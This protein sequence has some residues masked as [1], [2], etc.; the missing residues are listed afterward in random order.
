MHVNIMYAADVCSLLYLY[1]PYKT[2]TFHFNFSL[3]LCS[4]QEFHDAVK[5][6][7]T[8]KMQELIRRGVDIKIK[9]KVRY[10]EPKET[11]VNIANLQEL[12]EDWQWHMHSCAHYYI[13]HL[14]S[15]K[16]CL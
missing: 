6:N 9:N 5:R 14:T 10:T 3:V 7:D 12:V 8:V 15:S 13:R 1:K 16:R 4:E 11:Y 2:V